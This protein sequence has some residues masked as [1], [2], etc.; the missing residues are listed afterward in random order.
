MLG[1]ILTFLYVFTVF[2]GSLVFISTGI[3][4]FPL[5]NYVPT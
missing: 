2:V 1:L 5:V 3:N 4:F